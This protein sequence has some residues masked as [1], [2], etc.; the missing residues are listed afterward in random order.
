MFRASGE[1]NFADFSANFSPAVCPS[2]IADRLSF[3]RQA[4]L[5]QA[6]EIDLE[7]SESNEAGERES[8]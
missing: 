4:V 5:L 7:I 1:D 6:I 2:Q 8:K 3:L